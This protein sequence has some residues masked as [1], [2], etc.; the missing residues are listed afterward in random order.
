[1]V[2]D[3]S[4]FW[5]FWISQKKKKELFTIFLANQNFLW[6][7]KRV[8]ILVSVQIFV[9]FREFRFFSDFFEISRLN[10]HLAA[11]FHFLS[12]NTKNLNLS[13]GNAFFLE[14]FQEI[15]MYD[16]WIF[17]DFGIFESAHEIK[18]VVLRNFGLRDLVLRKTQV[19]YYEISDS[20]KVRFSYYEK[21]WYRVYLY[22]H[23]KLNSVKLCKMSQNFQRFS[24]IFWYFYFQ[25]SH[26]KIFENVTKILKTSC[27][28]SL[29]LPKKLPVWLSKSAWNLEHFFCEIFWKSWIPYITWWCVPFFKFSRWIS[30]LCAWFDILGKKVFKFMQLVF[31]IA[32]LFPVLHCLKFVNVFLR[33]PSE[34]TIIVLEISQYITVLN[35]FKKCNFWVNSCSWFSRF[36]CFLP[37][38]ISLKFINVLTRIPSEF[39]IIVLEFLQQISQF[40]TVLNVFKNATFDFQ[41]LDRNSIFLTTFSQTF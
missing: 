11:G 30:I 15:V 19:S 32:M 29:F 3:I 37:C 10:L 18:F 5:H 40:I 39:K 4:K 34:F 20:E 28:I 38:Y 12:K 17:P 26:G 8:K 23:P 14:I 35:N 6:L 22:T 2:N 16:Q 1:M 21:I 9:T 41:N 36:Q 13:G 24:C 7:K 33:I 25:I 27:M 31:K